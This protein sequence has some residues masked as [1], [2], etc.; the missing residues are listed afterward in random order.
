MGMFDESYVKLPPMEQA[1]GYGD[2]NA[3]MIGAQSGTQ[4]MFSALGKLAGFQ[5]EED[6]MQEIYDNAD[7]TT[8][9]GKQ[10]AVNEML[11]LNPE[12][13]KE[14]QEMLTAQSVGEAQLAT[15]ELAT[16]TA[17]LQNVMIK[18]G[19]RLNSEFAM[20]PA[21]GGQK[22]TI[23]KFL[24]LNNIDYGDAQPATLTQAMKYIYESYGSKRKAE[25]GKV[26]DAL[27][28]QLAVARS[29]W[30][31]KG[32][33]AI[34]SGDVE[35]DT[36]SMEE[37]FDASLLAGDAKWEEFLLNKKLKHE[38]EAKQRSFSTLSNMNL[39]AAG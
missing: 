27:K 16:E 9:E 4:G 18:H 33:L 25:A 30:V 36:Y 19:T 11:R 32:A 17:G 2:T 34:L 28:E 15:A 38:E 26:L 7:F 3:F 29:L 37:T 35:P 24:T 21:D 5:D 22:L 1:S 10:K 13:G 31:E 12:K 8:Q 20:T 6:L 39:S 14:L 23:M